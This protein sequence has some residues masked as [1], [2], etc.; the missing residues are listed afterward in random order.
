[1]W[2]VHWSVPEM[3][4][5]GGSDFAARPRRGP[6]PRLRVVSVLGLVNE[7]I[8]LPF[9]LAAAPRG[10]NYVDVSARRPEESLPGA[11]YHSDLVRG[12]DPAAP[13]TTP[14]ISTPGTGGE[15]H[16]V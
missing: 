11:R 14:L 9:G 1:M 2:G 3:G 12:M 7:R 16:L 4:A 15:T 6:A 13:F 5:A 10:P 8:E